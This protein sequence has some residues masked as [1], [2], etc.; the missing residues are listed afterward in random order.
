MDK[1]LTLYQFAKDVVLE[2]KY[3]EELDWQDSLDVSQISESDFLREY[4]WVVLCSG[5]KE[6]IVRSKFEYISMCFCDWSSS[7]EIVEKSEVC[8]KCAADAI[9]NHKK[10]AAIIDTAKEITY[11]GFDDFIEHIKSDPVPNL[12]KLS[13]IGKVTAYHLAKNIGIDV[14]KPDRHLV[15][16]A[17]AYDEGDVHSLCKKISDFSGDSIAMV[18]LILWRYSVMNPSHISTL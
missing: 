4:A 2:S 3:R 11:V 5:F 17:K 13:F 15:R 16:I 9:G 8:C 6:S 12:Q 14:A 7:K 18:D 1:I 10:L